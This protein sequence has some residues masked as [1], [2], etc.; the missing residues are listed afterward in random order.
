MSN[1]AEEQLALSTAL[2]AK[3]K[4]L[5]PRAKWLSD[6]SVLRYVAHSLRETAAPFP[7]Y[8]ASV[9]RFRMMSAVSVRVRYLASDSVSASKA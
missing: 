3:T 2:T 9:I 1:K 4:R 8:C 7:A 6:L 5:S